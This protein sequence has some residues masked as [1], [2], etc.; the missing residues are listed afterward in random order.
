MAIAERDPDEAIRSH[1]AVKVAAQ[2]VAAMGMME[3]AHGV[4]PA[5]LSPQ[6]RA[7]VVTANSG[8][9][10]ALDRCFHA[11]ATLGKTVFGSVAHGMMLFG[12]IGR[13]LKH[14]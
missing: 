14:I 7:L 10:R 12:V 8:V 13:M 2:T 4:V 6:S 5:T 9:N 1:P 11:T 3:A